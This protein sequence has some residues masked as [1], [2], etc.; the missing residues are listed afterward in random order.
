MELGRS[1]GRA[2]MTARLRATRARRGTAGPGW[3]TLRRSGGAQQAYLRTHRGIASDERAAEFLLLDRLF[4]RSIVF[5]LGQA[6]QCLTALEPV[7]DRTAID[8]AR[9]HLGHA[10]SSLEYRPLSEVLDDLP[11]GMERVQRACSAASDAVRGRYFPS[12]SL[13]SWVGEAL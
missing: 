3:P 11:G 8:E 10:R 6:D 2:E 4:P 7:T 12:G 1:L 5:A 13:T 9:R